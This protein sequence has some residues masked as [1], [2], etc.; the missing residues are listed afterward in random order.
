MKNAVSQACVRS[1]VIGF[2]APSGTWLEQQLGAPPTVLSQGQAMPKGYWVYAQPVSTWSQAQRAN[3]VMPP[4]TV[5]LIE[6]Q[7]GQS[8][9][10]TVYV[11]Q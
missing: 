7:A 10:V 11:Q 4:I 1:Q 3:R 9:A 6:A 8:L 5:A 2:I